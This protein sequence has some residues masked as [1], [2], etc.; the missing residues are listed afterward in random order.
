MITFE[1]KKS[2]KLPGL[3]SLYLT[4]NYN[5]DIINIIK[6]CDVKYFDKKK[7]EWEVPLTSLSYLID[8]LTLI[9]DIT[10]KLLKSEKQESLPKLHIDTSN[11][12]LQPYPYQLEAIEY[13]LQ[14]KKWLLL[15]QAG[16]GKTSVII[17]IAEELY[18][19][20]KIKHCLIICGINNLKFN[21]KLEIKKHS[22]LSSVIL[23]EK[24][25][26]KGKLRIG[27]VNDRCNHLLSD[28]KE[29]FVITNIETLRNDNIVKAIKK[30]KNN[31]DMIILDE[32]HTCKG[33]GTAQASNLLKLSDAQY[34]IGLSGTI[35]LN[36]PL[37]TYMPLRWIGMDSSCYSTFE[38]YYTSFTG[39]FK[40]VF[41]GYK[42]LDILKD[43]LDRCSL[44][45]KK[46]DVLDLPKK[47]IINEYVELD[48]R[49]QKF[50][51]NI[52]QGI[53][54]E[55]DKVKITTTSLL[56]M[57]SRL[58]QASSN[59]SI[60]TT[61]S[62]PSAKLQ[63]AVE[64]TKEIIESNNKVVIFSV[65]KDNVYKLSELLSEYD[66]LVN[67]GDIKDTVITENIDK[68]QNDPDKKIFLATSQKCGTGIT[69]TAASYMIFIDTPWTY[70]VYEQAQDRIYRIGTKDPVFIYNLIAKDTIDERV[71]QIVN[72]KKALSDY[73]IDDDMSVDTIAS[74][75]KFIEELN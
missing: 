63:R 20:G 56:A 24:Y 49:Q 15:D 61:E 5:I 50:Y 67:T 31:F 52:E 16:L 37:D 26:K 3:T 13:G 38:N 25:T 64:L 19:Q 73:V 72:N 10:L 40:T 69:L 12:P 59:P 7:R 60:L 70:G 23:G 36:K 74:L 47:T 55:V 22:N 45:R 6:L 29:F 53:I 65:F 75:R 57:V 44:R 43:Q 41:N 28:I 48:D 68:F 27:S 11:Y 54:D 35:L 17:H 62:I 33:T 39:P 71:L 14:H 8:N 18:K 1:E 46:E 42:H 4:F 34:K 9:D 58:R 66:P 30:S 21:W 32:A 2:K 51:D